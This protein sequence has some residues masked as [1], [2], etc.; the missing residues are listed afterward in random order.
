[1]H[2]ITSI[3]TAFLGQLPT[4]LISPFLYKDFIRAASNYC[5]YIILPYISH[6]CLLLFVIV[7]FTMLYYGHVGI[8][9]VSE[10]LETLHHLLD[11][12]PELNHTVFER[13]I[14]HLAR[15]ELCVQ[16]CSCYCVAGY[17]VSQQEEA[18]LMSP[19]NLAII[20]API[21]LKPP[22]KQPPQELLLHLPKQT[23]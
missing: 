6:C 5:V 18:N 16:T 23:K 3:V 7:V 9:S 4:S 20:F 22:Y 10:K 17:R 8:T 13:I 11:Q 2:C 14:F 19:N 15:Y 1:M 21:L 12:L